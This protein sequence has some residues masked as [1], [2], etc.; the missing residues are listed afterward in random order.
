MPDNDTKKIGEYRSTSKK[1]NKLQ[2]IKE[3]IGH[4]DKFEGTPYRQED[5]E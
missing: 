5:E 4:K 2:N 1:E 3:T